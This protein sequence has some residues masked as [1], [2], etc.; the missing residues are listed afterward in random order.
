M[1]LDI[2]MQ[3]VIDGCIYFLFCKTYNNFSLNI[4]GN[5]LPQLEYVMQRVINEVMEVQAKYNVDR[6]KY[7]LPNDIFDPQQLLR[8]L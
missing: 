7:F 6:W 5:M 8:C 3:Y 4:H 2:V 1:H